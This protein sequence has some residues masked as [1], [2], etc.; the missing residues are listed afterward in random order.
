MV[1][2]GQGCNKFSIFWFKV[3]IRLGKSTAVGGAV[4]ELTQYDQPLLFSEELILAKPAVI[5]IILILIAGLCKKEEISTSFPCDE[6]MV[7]RKIDKS[8][9]ELNHF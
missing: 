3:Q 9:S 8:L 4:T 7:Q 1:H 2:K 6:V 5:A